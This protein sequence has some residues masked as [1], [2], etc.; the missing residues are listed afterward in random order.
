VV[1]VVGFYD[2]ALSD[3][4]L[5]KRLCDL[6]KIGISCKKEK[7]KIAYPLSSKSDIN[8]YDGCFAVKFPSYPQAVFL[9]IEK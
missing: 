5:A 6:V 7:I 4:H 3:L 8:V 1:A 9:E 2:P